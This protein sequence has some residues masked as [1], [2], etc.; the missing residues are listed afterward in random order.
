MNEITID[1]FVKSD[2]RVGTVLAAEVPEWSHW[3]MRLRVDFGE[4]VGQRTVFSGIMKFFEPKDLQGNQYPFVIN[5]ARKRIGPKNSEGEYE[6]SEGMMIMAVP[7][8]DPEDEETPPVLFSLSS[9]V[10]NGTKVR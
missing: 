5:L 6:Y 7:N 10:P 9:S 4:E 1:D 8:E 3:V 2:I